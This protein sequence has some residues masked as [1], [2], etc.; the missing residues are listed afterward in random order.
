MRKLRLNRSECKIAFYL[1][2]THVYSQVLQSR[3]IHKKLHN[4]KKVEGNEDIMHTL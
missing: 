3:H 4:I 1:R 2:M